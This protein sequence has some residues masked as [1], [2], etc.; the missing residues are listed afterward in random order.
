MGLGSACGLRVLLHLAG[1]R[2]SVE[3]SEHVYTVTEGSKRDSSRVSAMT[4]LSSPARLRAARWRACRPVGWDIW[5]YAHAVEGPACQDARGIKP[6]EPDRRLV[7]VRGP[8]VAYAGVARTVVETDRE[9]RFGHRVRV[10]VDFTVVW[11]SDEL[12]RFHH[13]RK[14]D[15]SR[16][17]GASTH[18][19]ADAVTKTSE[20]CLNA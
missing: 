19:P 2:T 18:Q 13:R 17:V 11:S 12:G 7:C 20:S 3:A 9:Q 5:R 14:H 10:P 1:T 4:L 15:I 16:A 6:K 8:P